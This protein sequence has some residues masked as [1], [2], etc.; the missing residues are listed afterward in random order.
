MALLPL[1]FAL[2]CGDE[3]GP[4][5]TIRRADSIAVTA[6]PPFATAGSPLFPAVLVLDSLGAPLDSFPVRFTVL[7]GG[8]TVPA[9]TVFTDASGQ[10]ATTWT[11][12]DAIGPQ[13]LRIAAGGVNA[14]IATTFATGLPDSL[15]LL[16][17]F[18]ST[19]RVGT[20][21]TPAVRVL[22]S[23]G[24]PLQ[25]IAVAFTV[26]TGGGNVAADTVVTDSTGRAGT[27]WTL[28]GLVGTQSLRANTVGDDPLD[29]VLTTV[30][31]LPTRITK[32]AGDSQFL[33]AG[34]IAPIS[35]SVLVQDSFGNPASFSGVTWSGA[36]HAIGSTGTNAAGISTV[37]FWEMPP[38]PGDSTRLT[39]S[40]NGGNGPTVTFRGYTTGAAPGIAI[41]KIAG[42]SQFVARGTYVPILPSVE[43]RDTLGT[44]VAG[45]S[46]L[47]QPLESFVA[48][49][50]PIQST[51]GA[52]IATVGAWGVGGNY[53]ATYRLRVFA[54]G[55]RPTTF[56][57]RT[58]P[59]PP[60]PDTMFA[61]AGDSQMSAPRTTVPILPAVRV[62]DSLG[63]PVRDVGV[64]F[65]PVGD[66]GHLVIPG[67]G[68]GTTRFTDSSG[69]ATSPPWVLGTKPL[70]VNQ[71]RVTATGLDTVTFTA[72][73]T[74]PP[75]G[76][77]VWVESPDRGALAGGN[78]LV[79]AE[80]SSVDSIVSVR[81]TAGDTGGALARSGGTAWQGT[82][83]MRGLPLGPTLL[84]VTATNVHDSVGTDTLTFLHTEP[85]AVTVTA[86]IPFT[87][88][89]PSL[90]VQATC[91]YCNTL[92]LREISN[93]VVT[94]EIFAIGDSVINVTASLAVRDGH[95]VDARFVATNQDGGSGGSPL[96]RLFVESSPKLTT[97]TDLPSLVLD[98]EGART[99]YRAPDS[100][101][102]VL[103]N[104]VGGGDIVIPVDANER[105]VWA[106]LYPGG[107]IVR[108]HIAVGGIHTIRWSSGGAITTKVVGDAAVGGK[109]LV[110]HLSG[111]TALKRVDLTTG[112]EISIGTGNGLT[113]GSVG[114]NG[115]VAFV[116]GGIR[117]WHNGT[118]TLVSP[119][120]GSFYD[121]AT[122]SGR[123]IFEGVVGGAHQ[124]HYFNGTTTVLLADLGP[125]D[126]HYGEDYQVGGTW[127]AFLRSDHE[128]WTRSPAGVEVQVTS[129][130][131]GSKIDII[132]PD[133]SVIFIR[134]Y[135]RYYLAPGSNFWIDVASWRGSEMGTM[136]WTPTG[137]LE[138]LGRSVFAVTP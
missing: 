99:I 100:A 60:P 39:A 123:V 126:P 121:P 93:L 18:N 69:V 21:Q 132:G 5:E 89:R 71:L 104:S 50:G 131:I 82:I 20:V 94:P 32:I 58:N 101:S 29:I 30:W 72:T 117:L 115:D 129:H 138:L 105:I 51:D 133:G 67:G 73:T 77:A 95:W 28:G 59:P 136:K 41:D 36:L 111:N 81:V 23:E 109:Y 80:V 92:T 68:T 57:A 84:T 76:I 42:D 8:G 83:P 61:V 17:T 106:R 65:S 53:D 86:P 19:P 40:L 34:V 24:T 113:M 2:S 87:V 103:H 63:N 16:S 22:D 70:V 127:A 55:A 10:A 107:M 134:D 49:D 88:A 98:H 85:P 26:L 120:T 102:V 7:T 118:T 31:G 97:I 119:A 108:T 52:G 35:P 112:T 137:Y 3:G 114:S 4:G 79:T 66:Q 75:G 78:M 12:S 44:P 48:V 1:A 56:V 6:I 38:S 14:V 135:R 15:V 64:S 46:V 62:L 11:L 43:V 130:P 47:F 74:A 110:Y 37:G 116:N 124:V 27:N 25:G 45:T 13:T 96:F 128:I 54:R 122:D 9:D 91:I 90:T 33:P 125:Y